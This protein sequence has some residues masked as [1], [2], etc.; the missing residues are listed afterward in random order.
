[1]N[2]DNYGQWLS[3]QID[4][5]NRAAILAHQN[6]TLDMLFRAQAVILNVA[7]EQYHDRVRLGEIIETSKAEEVIS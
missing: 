6:P 5:L 7:L 1:M 2:S 3:E 4:I